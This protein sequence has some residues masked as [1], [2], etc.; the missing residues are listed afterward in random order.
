MT[1]SP[2]CTQARM[3]VMMACVAPAVMVISVSASYWRPWSASILAATAA[4]N[5]RMPG[6]GGDWVVALPPGP[7]PGSP[8]RGGAGGG[9][10][11]GGQGR[12]DGED[13]GAHLRQFVRQ[14]RCAGGRAGLGGFSHGAWRRGSQRS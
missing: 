3:A 12:H 7:G 2:G 5:G 14:G 13:G 6:I 4:R 10:V 1:S 11:V 9:V 8:P